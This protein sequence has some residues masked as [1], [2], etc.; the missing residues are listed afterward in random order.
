MHLHEDLEFDRL[1]E[2][3]STG[4]VDAS[5]V[6]DAATQVAPGDRIGWERYWR[7]AGDR[8]LGRADTALAGDEVGDAIRY[9]LCATSAFGLAAA[10]DENREM[11]MRNRASQVS[12]F[13]AAIPLL[14][15]DC[16]AVH[17]DC[18]SGPLYGYY[19]R[20]APSLS[21]ACV[22]IPLGPGDGVEEGYGR[23]ARA[24]ARA[25]TN[26]LVMESS[27]LVNVD[28]AAALARWV[29]RPMTGLTV[30]GRDAFAV[31]VMK[32]LRSEGMTRA[33]VYCPD[34]DATMALMCTAAPTHGCPVVVLPIGASVSDAF[35]WSQ[36]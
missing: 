3:A 25:G 34:T 11:Q 14:P 9:L 24:A 23:F 21:E 7:R 35:H 22:L 29:R 18:E 6:G 32:C 2:R 10:S 19:I 16:E 27:L 5:L 12:S 4:V 15:I 36:R 31:T 8:L 1:L 28:A 26:C 33:I 30:F 20:A 13:R 17:I